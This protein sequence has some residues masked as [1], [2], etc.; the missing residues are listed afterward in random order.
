MELGFV[1][2]YACGELASLG[3]VRVSQDRHRVRYRI[4]RGCTCSLWQT[5]QLQYRAEMGVCRHRLLKKVE[6]VISV[7]VR[8]AWREDNLVHRLCSRSTDSSTR[9]TATPTSGAIA[10]AD[11]GPGVT[12]VCRHLP[13]SKQ[14]RRKSTNNGQQIVEAIGQSECYDAILSLRCSRECIK[15]RN[16]TKVAISADIGAKAWRKQVTRTDSA[17]RAD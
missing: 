7:D 13:S 6:I 4:G 9:F 16:A 5:R 10:R 11:S 12:S 15:R 17:R 2:L 14:A 3:H 1:Y 8:G